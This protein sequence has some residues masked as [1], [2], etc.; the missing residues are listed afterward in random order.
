MPT[1]PLKPPFNNHRQL[2]INHPQHSPRISINDHNSN[3]IDKTA[4]L[5][6]NPDSLL[7]LSSQ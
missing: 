7:K 1:I 6:K 4:N 2:N 3:A 5:N